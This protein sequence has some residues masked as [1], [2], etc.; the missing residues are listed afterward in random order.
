MSEERRELSPPRVLVAV[1]LV[2]AAVFGG[3]VLVRHALAGPSTP[4]PQ[5]WFAPYVDVTLPPAYQFQERAANPARNVVLGFVVADPSSPCTPS[6]GGASSLEAASRTLD[7]DR[8]IARLEERGGTPIVSF[9][10]Q[11]N[12]ELA[13]ECTDVSAL[14]SAYR[15]VVDRYRVGTIDFDVEGAGLGNAAS[16]ARRAHAI[17]SVQHALRA[18]GRPL[19]VWLTLPAAPFGLTDRGVA[20]VDAML[21]AHVDLA[22]VNL[23]TMDFAPAPK[24]AAAMRKTIESALTG[25]QRQLFSAYVRAGVR[26]SQDHVWEKLGVTPMIGVNDGDAGSFDLAN[27]TALLAFVR[28]RHLGRVSLWSL[29]RDTP[30]GPNVVA[31]AVVS[32]SCSGLRQK[33][34]AFSSVFAALS[35]SP[36]KAAR[37][38]TSSDP[39]VKDNPKTS[40][41]PIWTRTNAYPTGYKVVWHGSVYKAKWFNQGLAP[42]A[43]VVHTWD[44]PWLLLG[45]VLPGEHA[46]KLP[47]LPAGTYPAWSPSAVYHAGTRI[48]YRG[49]P[50]QARWYTRGDRPATLPSP[51][52][53]SPWRPLFTIPG[54]PPP[55]G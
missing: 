55:T 50:Y 23:L 48:L 53:T 28:E 27:A 26:L 18:K 54:E 45:P 36:A 24:T 3:L 44:T 13:V 51:A 38:V 40:P 39:M 15:Q 9:G 47:T 8:R 5:G 29:N 20:A 37:L 41:Y 52:Q 12:S 30:C 31:A 1:L 32:N 19:A 17:A 11:R 16:I 2:A 34:L 7:L 49:L 6:W 43:P 33:P 21:A 22:G 10:G 46:P 4:Q 35:G 42:D 14:A 25:A